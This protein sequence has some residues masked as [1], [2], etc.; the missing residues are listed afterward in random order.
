MALLFISGIALVATAA[1]LLVRAAALP[2]MRVSSQMRQI[3]TYGFR[4]ADRHVDAVA[5]PRPLG[6]G[7][8]RLAEKVGRRFTGRGLLAPIENRMLRA[9]GMYDVLPET[10]QGYR[11]LAAATV[12]GLL[13]LTSLLG[14]GVQGTTIILI[15][16]GAGICWMLPPVVV[17]TRAQ[18]RMDQVD[19]RIPELID[20]LV[21]TVEAG[22][23]FAG[24]LQLVA[25][26]FDGPLGQELRLMLHE[27]SMGLSTEQALNNL[28]ERCDT[29]S[30]R[31]F[32]RAITQGETL[33]VS[34]GT[35]LRNLA[36]ESRKRRRQSVREKIQ[37]APVKML[38][39]LIFLIF[40]ALF[41]VLLYPAAV[42]LLTSLG[43]S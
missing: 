29:P 12:S 11:V 34:I 14:R 10:F 30:V 41:I 35:M 13:L 3:D 42:D 37:K 36:S 32:A 39:P 1:A 27:Q 2:R 7:L 28:L 19:R 38:F 9:A 18:R 21:A 16:A 5:A 31:A 25:A 24:S 43:A 4:A 33:G 17:K 15:L 26:R 23:G 22:L 6:V 40:P 20:V 8:Q